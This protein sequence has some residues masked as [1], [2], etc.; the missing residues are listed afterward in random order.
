MN[1]SVNIAQ[2]S[3]S[4]LFADPNALHYGANVYQNLLNIINEIKK[5]DRI[6]LIVFTGD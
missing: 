6:D 1:S 3:D 2:L 4:H 5:L